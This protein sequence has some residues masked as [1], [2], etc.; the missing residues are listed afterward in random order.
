M[1]SGTL[2]VEAKTLA[3]G[4]ITF[5]FRGQSRWAATGSGLIV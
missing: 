2:R 4:G 5:S 1:P 3:L